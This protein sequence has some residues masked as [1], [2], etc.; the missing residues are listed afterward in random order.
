MKKNTIIKLILTIAL[1]IAI[2]YKINPKEI[3]EVLLEIDLG[4]FII[5]IF[6]VPILYILRTYRWKLYLQHLG[7]NV[8]FSKLLKTLIIGQFYGLITPGKLGEF[9]RVYHLHASKAVTIPTVIAE[10]IVD[11]FVLSTLG[12]ITVFI[13]FPSQGVM[14]GLILVFLCILTIGVVILTNRKSVSY[15]LKR[16]GVT[17]EGVETYIASILSLFK[18]R[19]LMGRVLLTTV[20]YYAIN[21]IIGYF[22][23]LALNVDVIA[24]ITIP[25]IVLIGN[26]PITISGLGLRES[27]GAL[28]F[29]LLGSEGTYGFSFSLM[30][31]GIITLIPGLVGYILAMKTGTSST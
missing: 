7:V 22:V 16:F 30:L 26:V 8:H 15:I 18:H 5:A 2:F 25:I 29:T 12:L 31:F 20:S 11:L 23:L 4:Y 6:F 3:I 13:F 14:V 21:Y 27:V 19:P 9:G 17:E 10:K 1:F 24:V 28:C